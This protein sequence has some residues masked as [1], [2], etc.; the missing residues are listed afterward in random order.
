MHLSLVRAFARGRDCYCVLATP[1]EAGAAVDAAA[2]A[3]REV[4]ELQLNRQITLADGTGYSIIRDGGLFSTVRALWR[5]VPAD[6]AEPAPMAVCWRERRGLRLRLRVSQVDA[7]ERWLW[8]RHRGWFG[9][10]AN[11]D[12]VAVAAGAE[13]AGT[14]PVLLRVE[15]RGGWRQNLQAT[16]LAPAELPLP[17][18]VFVFSVLVEE[19]RRAAAAAAAG[20]AGV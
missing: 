19:D 20:A 11:R 14:D 18:V 1:P 15:R 3:T 13:P 4:A 7:P 12:V 6:A 2:E 16:W 17:L 9:S 8:L 10:P 5:G